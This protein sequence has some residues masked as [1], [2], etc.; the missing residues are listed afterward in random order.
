MAARIEGTPTDMC[1]T[2]F[3]FFSRP[4]GLGC[5]AG[6]RAEGSGT[7]A[8]SS[9][10]SPSRRVMIFTPRVLP[11]T[12]LPSGADRARRKIRVWREVV[13]LLT[14]TNAE[15]WLVAGSYTFKVRAISDP[16]V[17]RSTCLAPVRAFHSETW[18]ARLGSRVSRT[19]LAPV[20]KGL[21]AV[22]GSTSA[23]ALAWRWFDRYRWWSAHQDKEKRKAASV[24]PRRLHASP[25]RTSESGDNM[26][27]L[28][29]SANTDLCARSLFPRLE[30]NRCVC[31]WVSCI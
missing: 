31:L 8:V 4:N 21:A 17:G 19:R 2:T 11:L 22:M 12:F 1:R 29:S 14:E 30:I 25:G 23:I 13:E 24:S 26:A 15:D 18:E 6:W 7:N 3:F 10:L 27:A 9:A 5:S 20:G 16:V 28:L